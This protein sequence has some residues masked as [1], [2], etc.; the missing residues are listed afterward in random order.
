MPTAAPAQRIKGQEVQVRIFEN[1]KLVANITEVKSFEISLQ[2]EIMKEGYLGETTDRRD[3]VFRGVTGKMDVHMKDP[4]VFTL[5]QKIADRAQRRVAGLQ[6]DVRATFNFP[7]GQ[8]KTAVISNLFFGEMPVSVGGRTEYVS[9][10]LNFE[11]DSVN[12][13][14]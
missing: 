8:Q 2:T 6:I 1:N 5:I 14:S 9:S 13:I 12:F 11:A 10:T 7:N 4:S 3:E